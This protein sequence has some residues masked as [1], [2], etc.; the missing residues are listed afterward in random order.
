MPK[1]S[2][3]I[4]T[5]NEEQNIARCLDSVQGVADDVVVLDS[6][7]TDATE[8]ISRKYDV[9]FIQRKWEG[10]SRTKNFANNQAKYDWILSLDADE[11][12][13]D[14]LRA[15][16]LEIKSREIPETCSFNRLT[17]YCGNWIR[18]SGWY[19]DV[20]VRLFERNQGH[21]EGKIHE[22]LVFKTE[23]PVLHL[24]GD[25]AVRGVQGPDGA[26]GGFSGVHGCSL[27]MAQRSGPVP[28]CG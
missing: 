2:V 3:V 23:M 5:F 24:E 19:P 22:Q 12:L 20:K 18:H 16:I 26:R 8:R 27:L 1:L 14:K 25:L 4:I 13:S 21:W 15:S 11:A 10:Y 28:G 17:N 6:F 9:N 7:S